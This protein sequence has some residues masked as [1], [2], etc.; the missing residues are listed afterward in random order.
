MCVSRFVHVC[1]KQWPIMPQICIL[2][3]VF[4]SVCVHLFMYVQVSNV[5]LSLCVCK[6]NP[7]SVWLHSCTRQTTSSIHTKLQ[8]P[9]SPD[10][11]SVRVCVCSDF[12]VYV[13]YVCVFERERK[14]RRRGVV[15]RISKIAPEEEEREK[16]I[17]NRK[18]IWKQ[19]LPW[20]EF[21]PGQ[22]LFL[23]FWFLWNVIFILC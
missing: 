13:S 18:K 3:H 19:I 17:R 20:K 23:P 22:L 11:E 5:C 10:Q 21:T 6:T 1:V 15:E 14:Q 16:E 4:D 8:A 12:C 2:A 7:S 9:V